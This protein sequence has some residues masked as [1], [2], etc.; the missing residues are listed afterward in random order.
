M[1][2]LEAW[3]RSTLMAQSRM[4]SPRGTFTRSC[5][6]RPILNG[7]RVASY[8]QDLK[9]V[10]TGS[11]YSCVVLYASLK[12]S[13]K[14]TLILSEL[15]RLLKS[16]AT[17]AWNLGDPDDCC[18]CRLTGLVVP[19]PAAVATTRSTWDMMTLRRLQYDF[20][21]SIRLCFDYIS[22]F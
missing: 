6:I 5:L 13:G 11:P 21:A 10:S 9:I 3:R 4:S 20:T 18:C 15:K 19:L 22:K 1:D 17:P 7:T 16:V 8:Y 12:L 2:F 14:L